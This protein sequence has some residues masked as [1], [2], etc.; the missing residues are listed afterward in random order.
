MRF[1]APGTTKP[2]ELKATKT[3]A[4]LYAAARRLFDDPASGILPYVAGTAAGGTL[5][6]SKDNVHATLLLED[7]AIMI[8]AGHAPGDG[9]PSDVPAA[10]VLVV[11]GTVDG[12][13]VHQER[14]RYDCR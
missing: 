8:R 1:L 11:D 6:E 3:N 7:P 4:E 2:V 9:A 13:Q 12:R 10:A 14:V 5:V